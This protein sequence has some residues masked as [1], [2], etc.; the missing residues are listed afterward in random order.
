M[1]R[2]RCAQYCA[3]ATHPLDLGRRPQSRRIPVVERRVHAAR[4]TFEI[5]HFRIG[6]RSRRRRAAGQ[7]RS[8]CCLRVPSGPDVEEGALRCPAGSWQDGRR[9]RGGEARR[10]TMTLCKSNGER[11]PTTF[12]YCG[13]STQKGRFHRLQA[14]VSCTEAGG[15]EDWGRSRCRRAHRLA[16]VRRPASSGIRAHERLARAQWRLNVGGRSTTVARRAC[17]QWRPCSWAT[18]CAL[19]ST[20]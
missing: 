11:V 4:Q 8:R 20:R 14:V 18:A 16:P 7:C 13:Y 15:D 2:Q 9:L 6:L 1:G 10:S 5:G 12:G 3:D 19:C 17:F